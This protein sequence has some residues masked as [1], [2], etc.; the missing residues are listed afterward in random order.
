MVMDLVITSQAEEDLDGIQD[1]GDQRRVAKKI[2]SIGDKVE[3]DVYTAEQAT[4]KRLG[5]GWSPM[6]QSRAG[7]YRLWFVQGRDAEKGEEGKLYLCRVLEKEDR[8][9][10]RGLNINPSTYL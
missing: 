3:D 8:M 4:K 2:D 7:D 5:K 10:L 9:K 6:L 1:S